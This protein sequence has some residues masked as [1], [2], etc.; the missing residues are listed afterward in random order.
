[1][2][3]EDNDISGWGRFRTTLSNGWQVGMDYDA[4]VRAI[5]N[6]S[7]QLQRTVV[8]RNRFR[9]PR[10]T[11]NSWDFGHPQGPQ[12]LTYSFCG[13]NHVIRYNEVYSSNGSKYFNDGLGGEDNFSDNGF[14]NAD[15]DIY[16]N[17][18]SH[19]WDDG[20]EAEG[21]N[22]N[23]RIWGNYLDRV[24]SGIATTSTSAGPV[25]I[26]RNVYNRSQKMAL[27]PLDSGDR[28]NFAKSGSDSTYGNG[29]RYVFHNTL[30]QATQSG[31]SWPLG[32]AGGIIAGG[33]SQPTTNTVSRNNI[34]HTFRA[35]ADSIRTQGGGSN[36]FDYD[37]RNG[38]V[39]AYAG[40]EPNGIVAT[41]IYAAGHG[42]QSEAGGRYQLDRT[43]RGYDEGVR[44]PNF[45]DGHTGSGPDMGAHEADTPAMRFGVGG[46]G[47]TWAS[48]PPAGASS[49]G[50]GTEGGSGGGGVCSTISCAAQ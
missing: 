2:V 11:S 23:V 32:A 22:R 28:L 10:Y 29:R 25:Y 42:W 1:V 19:V 4:A 15:S 13:G 40:A 45:N 9:D 12:G 20:I 8:Q 27:Q 17:R 41:P 50:E 39:N 16:G 6:A 7:F 3:I 34:L 5:C 33:T 30:L 21:A 36:D 46:A 37:L 31:L 14:P 38:G 48:A 49:A 24:A 35:T 26:F 44:L 43:S 18:I 47:S